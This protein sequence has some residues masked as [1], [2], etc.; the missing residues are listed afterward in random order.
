MSS[1]LDNPVP[2]L[3]DK[4]KAR[5]ISSSA[6]LTPAAVAATADLLTEQVKHW[7]SSEV[8]G[9]RLLGDALSHDD[10]MANLE[11]REREFEERTRAAEG[12]I[13]NKE[14]IINE[15]LKRMARMPSRTQAETNPRTSEVDARNAATTSHS[16]IATIGDAERLKID[17][18]NWSA[19]VDDTKERMRLAVDNLDYLDGV[20]YN[21]YHERVV[22]PIML[23]SVVLPLKLM[24]KKCP[25]SQS[26][27]MC[28]R[29]HL[30]AHNRA[31][32]MK[33]FR[34][35]FHFKADPDMATGDLHCIKD[36]FDELEALGVKLN[37]DA[38]SG[39]VLQAGLDP[40]SDLYRD[41]ENRI[42]REMNRSSLSAVPSFNKILELYDVSRQHS[43]AA[44]PSSFCYS[45]PPT[46]SANAASAGD[47]FSFSASEGSHTDM[48]H[49]SDAE[50]YVSGVPSC[51]N[52]GSLDH[53]K[54]RCPHPIFDRRR[55]PY[56]GTAPIAYRGY[57]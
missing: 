45:P 49:A 5:R 46:V 52:C 22:R 37:S 11:E 20:S 6:H 14:R 21:D 19:W 33:I 34:K 8:L 31:S 51:W 30:H 1:P 29:E 7:S 26:M 32:Q 41:F 17:G 15:H 27:F 12:R 50:A 13:A 48:D 38:L 54:N 35:I 42:D 43:T 4:H 18:S 56:R 28:L 25:T 16:I 47:V 2:S 53:M 44:A 24:L 36:A 55:L 3:K 9:Y 57:N 40:S 10:C 39:F 23:A